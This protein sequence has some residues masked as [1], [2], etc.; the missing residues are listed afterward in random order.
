MSNNDASDNALKVPFIEESDVGFRV[1]PPRREMRFPSG[2][3]RGMDASKWLR[4]VV[5]EELRKRGMTG[6]DEGG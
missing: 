4:K 6:G 5:V 3:Q 1:K 2:Q